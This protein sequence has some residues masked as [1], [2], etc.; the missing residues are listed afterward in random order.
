MNTKKIVYAA[1]IS[2]LGFILLYLGAILDILDLCM[3]VLASLLL[4]VT[5]LE[6]NIRYSLA[7]LFVTSAL[8]FFLLPN[9]YLVIEY[10]LYGGLYAI[11]KSYFEKFNIFLSYLLKLLYFNAV[12]TGLIFLAI[13]VFALPA[14]SGMAF[15]IIVYLIANAFFIVAD[16]AFTSVK[17]LYFVSL[18]DKLRIYRIFR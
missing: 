6:S 2:A 8:C 1:T 4:Y 7:I 18:R 12:L 9:K 11:L 10:L 5:F 14:D 13:Y 15:S 17:R 3:I 16:F